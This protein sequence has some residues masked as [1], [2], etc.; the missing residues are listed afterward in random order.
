VMVTLISQVVPAAQRSCPVST[1]VTPS[2]TDQTWSLVDPNSTRP[3]EPPVAP[4]LSHVTGAALSTEIFTEI[5]AQFRSPPWLMVTR[6]R[7]SSVPSVVSPFASS[8]SK[9][10]VSVAFCEGACPHKQHT[11]KNHSDCDH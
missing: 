4:G 11:S 2:P 5:E 6:T 1:M 7:L 10:S 9:V 3:H 8:A